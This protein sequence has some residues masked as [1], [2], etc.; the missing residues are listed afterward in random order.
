MK[1]Q[2]LCQPKIYAK[3]SHNLKGE[4][5]WP[6]STKKKPQLLD[7][8]HPWLVNIFS[9]GQYKTQRTTQQGTQG[10]Q[11]WRPP[12]GDKTQRQ[13]LDYLITV[14]KWKGVG[15]LK[16]PYKNKQKMIAWA[17]FT[18]GES[19]LRAVLLLFAN[20][21]HTCLVNSTPHDADSFW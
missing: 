11:A 9:V 21:T 16:K 19:Q 17:H 18:E 10:S 12:P 15:Y 13:P 7:G 1:W 14:W 6:T 5:N 2:Q 20:G 3:S 8:C 4:R